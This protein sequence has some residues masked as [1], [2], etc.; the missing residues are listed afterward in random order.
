MVVEEFDAEGYAL[1][2]SPVKVYYGAA[3]TVV[4]LAVTTVGELLAAC[5]DPGWGQT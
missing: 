5:G 1:P 2:L 3:D 4:G